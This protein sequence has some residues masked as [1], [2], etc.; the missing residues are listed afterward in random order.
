MGINNTELIV[1]EQS[2]S[3][4]MPVSYRYCRAYSQSY[5]SSRGAVLRAIR[6]ILA[7]LT[8]ILP[9]RPLTQTNNR[10]YASNKQTNK[11]PSQFER[12][13]QLHL[14]MSFLNNLHQ[15]SGSRPMLPTEF[16]S[17]Q[18]QQNYVHKLPTSTTSTALSVSE[19]HV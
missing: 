11:A 14:H 12:K 7:I 6:A 8:L 17:Q 16:C 1:A 13:M 9:V 10:K 4:Y 5:F 18:H 3:L 15:Q 19:V 2:I